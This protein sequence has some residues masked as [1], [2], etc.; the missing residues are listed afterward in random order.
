[1]SK[2]I[3][4]SAIV[5][6]ILLSTGT[7]YAQTTSPTPTESTPTESTRTESTPSEANFVAGELIRLND[8]GAWSWFMDERAIVDRDKLIVGSV[9]A[10]KSWGSGQNDPN[11][12]NVEVAVHDLQSGQTGKTVLHQHFEQDDHDNPAFLALPDG[13]YLCIYTKHGAELKIYIRHS[14]P[15]DPL[16][17]GDATVF[18][19]PG[20]AERFGG[21]SVT[22]SNLFRFSSGR[23]YNFY[24]GVGHDPNYMYSDDQG[25]SWTYGGR[26]MKGRDGYSPY[27]KYVQDGD[28]I[29]FVAT[30]DHPRNFDNSLYHGLVRDRQLCHSDGSVVASLSSDMDTEIRTWDFTRVFQG[31]PDNVAWMTDI[32]LDNEKHPVILFSVQKDGRGLPPRQGGDD[33]RY[34]YARWDG[35]QW[36]QREIAYAGK[37]LY[38]FEDDYPGLAAIHPY[39]P[40]T[41]F[42]STNADPVT[43]AP[44]ISPAD[45]QRHYEIYR[46]R[47][48][49]GGNTWQWSP[50]TANSTEDNLR[51]IV[52]KWRDERTAIVWMRGRYVH[53]HGEW[54]TAVV[55]TILPPTQ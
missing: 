37:R 34:H 51:P 38:P 52:P 27:L 43:G 11:W 21:D 46:G 8:N 29:H 16:T 28:T 50:V 5:G 12:G 48:T 41:V 44:L 36:K 14:A 23:I 17:W 39:D 26:V 13:R 9:R 32:E 1:M 33:L 35:R 7:L 15:N 45:Q 19:S 25:E 53:N 20:R 30:E 22:Y 2:P 42:I 18:N 4:L 47:S 49:D 54:T 3:T 55:A 40:T 31:D 10:V 24:R 6:L